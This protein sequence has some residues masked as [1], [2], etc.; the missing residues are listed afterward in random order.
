MEQAFLN[1]FYSELY[2]NT[3]GVT[4]RLDKIL[5]K[6]N[7]RPDKDIMFSDAYLIYDF[8]NIVVNVGNIKKILSPIEYKKS[9]EST[10]HFQNRIKR[11]KVLRERL[12]IIGNES[13]LQIKVRNRIEHFDERIDTLSLKY[14]NEDEE[15]K[16]F[17]GIVFNTNF[18]YKDLIKNHLEELSIHNRDMYFLKS[19]I[20]QTNELYIDN[21]SIDL[22]ELLEDL[23]DLDRKI[24]NV[25]KNEVGSNGILFLWP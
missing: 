22:Q 24:S 25:L 4:N 8:N 6:I 12:G 18:T 9:G 14:D 15:L 5:K 1:M 13:F 3:Q 11:G 20:S 17:K 7:Y 10:I 21:I 16:A 19:Y 23:T 2:I